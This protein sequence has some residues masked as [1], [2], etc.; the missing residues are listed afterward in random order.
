MIGFTEARHRKHCIR[1]KPINFCTF[2]NYSSGHQKHFHV[3]VFTH[4]MEKV[5]VVMGFEGELPTPIS[6][7]E[8]VS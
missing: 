7:R 3:V 4:I 1:T 6:L 2:G 5:E 8:R